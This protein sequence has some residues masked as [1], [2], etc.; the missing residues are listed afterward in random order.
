M[1]NKQKPSGSPRAVIFVCCLCVDAGL[2]QYVDDDR[3]KTSYDGSD[4]LDAPVR[5]IARHEDGTCQCDHKAPELPA[6]EFPFPVDHVILPLDTPE[7]IQGRKAAYP[8]FLLTY[9]L[10]SSII[11]LER[12]VT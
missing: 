7:F 11:N 6:A 1:K 4:A 8:P 2:G 12:Q 9:L 10:N 5:H 3:G